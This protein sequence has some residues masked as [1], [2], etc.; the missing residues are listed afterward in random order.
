MAEVGKCVDVGCECEEQVRVR[1]DLQMTELGVDDGDGRLHGLYPTSCGSPSQLEAL[2]ALREI[3]QC[4]RG[5][6]QVVLRGLR[7]GDVKVSRR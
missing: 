2:E 7:V 3:P 4:F 6:E 1:L 5:A